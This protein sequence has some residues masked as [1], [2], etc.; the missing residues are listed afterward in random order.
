MGIKNVEL[1]FPQDLPQDTPTI[2]P[3]DRFTSTFEES[4]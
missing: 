3:E 4:Y 2:I 1:L